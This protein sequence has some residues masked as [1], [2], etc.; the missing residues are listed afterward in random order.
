MV[1]YRLDILQYL[2]FGL[3]LVMFLYVRCS[4]SKNEAPQTQTKPSATKGGHLNN[5]LRTINS[6]SRFTYHHPQNLYSSHFLN[7]IMSLPHALF[8]QYTNSRVVSNFVKR[9]L[10]ITP[11]GGEDSIE[12]NIVAKS[13]FV[14]S[15]RNPF[16][17]ICAK[18]VFSHPFIILVMVCVVCNSVIL[19]LQDPGL[20]NNTA[21]QTSLNIADRAFLFIFTMEMLLKIVAQGFILHPK[22]Y[23]RKGWNV[24]DFFV[25][26]AGIIDFAISPGIEGNGL[27]AIRV[28]RVLRPLR[29]V[30][31]IPAL[32]KVLSKLISS[33][34]QMRDVFVL[35]IFGCSILSILGLHLFA[36]ELDG[37]CYAD[38]GTNNAAFFGF[39]YPGLT[40]FSAMD[41]SAINQSSGALVLNLPLNASVDSMKASL[42]NLDVPGGKSVEDSS[43]IVTL[44]TGAPISDSNGMLVGYADE[45]WWL[46]ANDTLECQVDKSSNLYNGRKCS[47]STNGVTLPQACIS[48]HETGIEGRT[49]LNFDNIYYSFLITL[50]IVCLDNWP[51]DLESLSNAVGVGVFPFFFL[52]TLVV[53]YFCINLFVAVLSNA[54]AK[55][56]SDALDRRQHEPTLGTWLGASFSRDAVLF[57]GYMKPPE[58]TSLFTAILAAMGRAQNPPDFD[59]LPKNPQSGILAENMRCESVASTKMMSSEEGGDARTGAHIKKS[60][61]P[62]RRPKEGEGTSRRFSGSGARFT[63]DGGGSGFNSATSTPQGGNHLVLPRRRRYFALDTTPTTT[64]LSQSQQQQTP[65][66]SEGRSR[67]V[68]IHEGNVQVATGLTQFN[69]RRSSYVTSRSEST[70]GGDFDALEATQTPDVIVSTHDFWRGV[71]RQKA[72]RRRHS[73]MEFT[74]GPGGSDEDDAEELQRFDQLSGSFATNPTPPARKGIVSD[75][76]RSDNV[77]GW[78]LFSRL[79]A[80][81]TVVPEFT[82]PTGI[83]TGSNGQKFSAPTST[84]PVTGASNEPFAKEEDSVSV[85]SVPEGFFDGV[86]GG[87]GNEDFFGDSVSDDLDAEGRYRPLCDG[88]CGLK[89]A[90]EHDELDD[91]D[92]ES[93]Y[94]LYGDKIVGFQT[95]C[96]SRIG[97]AL[98]CV[99]IPRIG[100]IV[101]HPFYDYVLIVVVVANSVILSLDHFGASQQIEDIITLSGYVF[102]SIFFFDST[103]KIV[104]LGASYFTEVGNIL[105]FVLCLVSINDFIASTGNTYAVLRTFRLLRMLRLARAWKKL[106]RLLDLIAGALAGTASIAL[107]SLIVIYIY[108]ILGFQLFGIQLPGSRFSFD[109]VYDSL[110]S[111]F[112]VVTGEDWSTMMQL[113][114]VET[115][116]LAVLYFVS[117]VFIGNFVIT[118]LFVA[119]VLQNFDGVIERGDEMGPT[120][121]DD[122]EVLIVESRP[123]DI[124][125]N[126]KAISTLSR[127]SPASSALKKFSTI[128]DDV[129]AED[130]TLLDPTTLPTATEEVIVKTTR[131]ELRRK[132]QLD[133]MKRLREAAHLGRRRVGWKPTVSFVDDN[134]S[135]QQQQL[136]DEIRRAQQFLSSSFHAPA[137]PRQSIGFL[138]TGGISGESSG[139]RTTT[140]ASGSSSVN[141]TKG[142]KEAHIEEAGNVASRLAVRRKSKARSFISSPL[143]SLPPTADH[144]RGSSWDTKNSSVNATNPVSFI[145][146]EDDYPGNH[147][148]I[149]ADGLEVVFPSDE[150]NSECTTTTTAN[151]SFSTSAA[152][153]DKSHGNSGYPSPLRSRRR[154][155]QP[156]CAG[157]A[158][159]AFSDQLR[160]VIP[161]LPLE[162]ETLLKEFLNEHPTNAGCKIKGPST[163]LEERANTE[164]VRRA[165]ATM[166]EEARAFE[167]REIKRAKA[168]A[169]RVAYDQRLAV[170]KE[171]SRTLRAQKGGMAQYY[172]QQETAANVG[173]EGA[174][175]G[176]GLKVTSA[177]NTASAAIGAINTLGNDSSNILNLRYGN[178]QSSF[179]R[180][181][182]TAERQAEL[183]FWR[184]T[185]ESALWGIP[186]HSRLR[187]R[188]TWVLR[189]RLFD[190]AMTLITIISSVLLIVDYPGLEEDDPPLFEALFATDILLCF[191][192]AAEMVLKVF[193]QGLI[194]HPGAYFRS[195]FNIIDFIVLVTS[196]GAYGISV[197]KTARSLRILRLLNLS[198]TL[199][200][201]ATSLVSALP[202]M[203]SVMVFCVLLFWIFGVLGVGLL[204]GRLYQCSDASIFMK[205]DCYGSVIS[206][207][208]SA[209]GMASNVTN[210]RQWQRIHWSSHFDSLD[211]SLYT[212][213]K[214]SLSDNWY[215]PM[216]DAV[217]STG[218]DSGPQRN[219]SEAYSLYF[220]VFMLIGNFFAVNLF[221]GVLVEQFV[222]K[223]R[224][225]EGYSL[226]TEAQRQWVLMQKVFLRTRFNVPTPLPKNRIRRLCFVVAQHPRFRWVVDGLIVVS[227]CALCAYYYNMPDNVASALHIISLTT[228]SL[229][230]LEIVVKAVAFGLSGM[231]QDP[232]TRLD[233]VVVTLSWVGEA[234]AGNF[235]VV[236]VFRVLRLAAIVRKFKGIRT[237][238]V[239]L[240]HTL[241]ELLNVGVVLLI[242]YFIMSC[243]CVQLFHSVPKTPGGAIDQVLNFD[244]VGRAFITLYTM[245]TTE[246]WSDIVDAVAK[247]DG[248]PSHTDPDCGR[249]YAI[250]VFVFFVCTMTWVLMNLLV[251]VVIDGFAEAT[252]A[253][254]KEG[255]LQILET[256]KDAWAAHDTTGSRVLPANTVLKL[257]PTLPG[258][259]WDRSL[260][261]RV[262][263][264]GLVLTPWI[265]VLRQL[266]RLHIPVDKRLYVRFDDVVAS[267]GLRL[268]NIPVETATAVSQRTVYGVTWKGNI[269]SIHHHFA[270]LA[271]TRKVRFRAQ[272]RRERLLA[273][274]IMLIRENERLRLQYEIA[275]LR[276]SNDQAIALIDWLTKR[277]VKQQ[278][279]GEGALDG[280]GKQQAPL[281]SNNSVVALSSGNEPFGEESTTLT[282]YPSRVEPTP[283]HPSRVRRV[284]TRPP[285]SF[286]R[287]PFARASHDAR[288][289]TSVF[290][291]SSTSPSHTA[292]NHDDGESELEAMSECSW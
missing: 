185:Q 82:N 197:L 215:V 235:A 120:E 99:G 15:Y 12:M 46:I 273:N 97:T 279:L 44:S 190:F 13:L 193:V 168:N 108:A 175:D 281:K 16:R 245:A 231:L 158:A 34:P 131:R 253:T 237:L 141:S 148:F 244:N 4:R 228:N 96:E 249:W 248:C 247:P 69:A 93:E 71:A 11:F 262:S 167:E 284:E 55:D 291:S 8:P 292:A 216:Y 58:T 155:T 14:F 172:A 74:G 94:D 24:L 209:F 229:F 165:E 214:I 169:A 261:G 280:S 234:V 21:L 27:S 67:A 32:R 117:A 259:I 159:Q 10:G 5:Q 31:K 6:K 38:V 89:G 276:T 75:E 267:I 114:T 139:R 268:L 112:I 238:L 129:G 98:R 161:D 255:S 260:V 100:Q 252:V 128:G 47:Q 160:K 181:I 202:G 113:A 19:A 51:Q 198:F 147:P 266:E 18:F 212:L 164:I 88:W 101:S 78:T 121:D 43:G 111:V 125:S 122:E 219:A 218:N 265:M 68:S 124:N 283:L 104:G 133:N 42:R 288:Q 289:D 81:L 22:A 223:R 85:M 224:D 64:S 208:P 1:F 230:T 150:N 287:T 149:D 206:T 184:G 45:N 282:Q 239:T 103:I 107:V 29:T 92:I 39:L 226:L 105:D 79:R 54:F 66:T 221:V 256:F 233:V 65:T 220:I 135:T 115:G 194:S 72:R 119:N 240:F 156:V 251:T 77:K 213:L 90:P 236:R 250:P 275:P 73:L 50:K 200:V 274:Q 40:N 20:A 157:R 264:D 225:G 80:F 176:S 83:D 178:F 272:H 151:S 258:T 285:I 205:D 118:N 63:S 186:P 52:C 153:N 210:H 286:P 37:R 241:P 70:G 179:S 127:D 109:S 254:E 59:T 243:F 134:S 110:L 130:L 290:T 76:S 199:R 7:K 257:L 144:R 203:V 57:A 17:R 180:V 278:A 30:S 140:I 154:E 166:E 201:I 26:A 28:V 143:R 222:M 142:L 174:L 145:N 132:E 126:S 106:Q 3:L 171:R 173:E 263:P 170:E 95:T 48:R 162:T 137:S 23:L 177:E 188:C 242:F 62:R 227:C 182:T 102:S 269:F 25:V 53:G 192:F 116:Q 246:G 56:E 2:L 86:V 49:I 277:L 183:A 60:K 196:I 189:H 146:T 138:Q 41:G 204:K 123:I 271:V 9:D 84:A 195:V 136:Q 87:V 33:L 217:Y 36:G 187:Q 35:L 211:F 163:T 191:A 152:L 232:F 91:S 207:V 61:E 270:A